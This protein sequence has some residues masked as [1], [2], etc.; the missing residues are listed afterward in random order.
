[1]H[2]ACADSTLMLSC[3][4][5]AQKCYY[6]VRI[7]N[8][9]TAAAGTTGADVFITLTG[10]EATT[11]RVSI[12]GFSERHIG[13][14]SSCTCEDLIIETERSLGEVLVVVLGI[15]GGKFA[16]D[17]TWFVQYT[18]VKDLATS[19]EV[20]FPCYH[21]IGASQIVSSTSKTSE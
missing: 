9:E 12:Y 13:G 7:V 3:K 18:V 8:G 20:E 10:S 16:M 1:M 11:Q 21:W 4:L 6:G 14:V 15:N 17:S 5:A 19:T 2:S